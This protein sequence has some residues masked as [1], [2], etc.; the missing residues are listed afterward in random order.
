MNWSL[1]FYI[2]PAVIA[3]VSLIA[4][5]TIY[6][7]KIPKVSSL[8]LDAMPT[9]RQALRKSAL[10]EDRLARKITQFKQTLKNIIIPIIKVIGSIFKKLYGQMKKLEDKYKKAAQT[11]NVKAGAGAVAGNQPSVGLLLQEAIKFYVEGKLDQAENKYISAI[12]AD[13]SSVEAYRGLAKVYLQKK[14]RIHA[15]ETLEFIQQLNPKDETVLRDIGALYKEEGKHDECLEAYEKALELGP[16]NPKNLDALIDVAI[17]CQL[18]YKAQGTL[19]KLKEV[20][21]ENNKLEEYQKR[22]DEMSAT[23]TK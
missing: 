3:V 10:V 8:D 20:N 2:I 6:V 17:V 18:K 19:D 7:K 23:V 4:I 5:I 15:L 21:P 16:N 14:D 12:V 9:H 13:Q 1:L 11:T 22:I